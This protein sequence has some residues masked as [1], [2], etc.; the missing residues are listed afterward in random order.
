MTRTRRIIAVICAA[1]VVSV[2]SS[3]ALAGEFN[4]N[5]SGSYVQV[6]PHS[7]LSS[8]SADGSVA[9]TI[10]RV[11][12][13][14]HGFVWADAAIGAAGGIAIVLLL[15]GAGLTLAQRGSHGLRHA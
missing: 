15:A 1:V 7:T 8:A 2:S 6:P 12:V 4:V 3:S 5:S 14:S 9:P 10:V 11:R 13:A